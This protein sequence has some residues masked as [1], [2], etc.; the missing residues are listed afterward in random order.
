[1]THDHATGAAPAPATLLRFPG[2]H[3][4]G[5]AAVRRRRDLAIEGYLA[6]RRN[7][8]EALAD[9]HRA[10]HRLIAPKLEE[11]EQR[12]RSGALA[13]ARQTGDHLASLRRGDLSYLSEAKVQ[14]VEPRLVEQ[15]L[16]LGVHAHGE[17]DQP[18]L[19]HRDERQQLAE[20]VPR[21]FDVVPGVLLEVCDL[22]AAHLGQAQPLRVR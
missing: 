8:P 21:V 14:R 12:W 13:A 10:A 22:R 20:D 9:F 18:Q 19:V 4:P 7:G 2:V 6:L 15:H 11:F 1:M 17:V 16:R 5:T 3:A